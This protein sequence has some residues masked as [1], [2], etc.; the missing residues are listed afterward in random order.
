MF[1]SDYKTEGG[2]SFPRSVV[3]KIQD[4]QTEEWTISK[5]KVNPT[6]GADHFKKR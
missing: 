1:L 6:F 2:V 5:I 3:I 4:G